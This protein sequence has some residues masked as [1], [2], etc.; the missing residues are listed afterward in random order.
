VA[1]VYGGNVN[2]S[3]LTKNLGDVTIPGDGP[4]GVVFNSTGDFVISDGNGHSGPAIFIFV[5]EDGTIAGWNPAPGMGGVL[6]IGLAG[7]AIVAGGGF[8]S[9]G[10]VPRANLAAIDLATGAVTS[11]WSIGNMGALQSVAIAAQSRCVVLW[12]P[13]IRRGKANLQ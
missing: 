10:G 4:T 13:D 9:A 7:S 1:S 5:T 3:P 8:V 2:H 6:A 12:R 11:C